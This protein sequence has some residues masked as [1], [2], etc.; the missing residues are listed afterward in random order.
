[1]LCYCLL[2]HS[3]IP[4]RPQHKLSELQ[5]AGAILVRE[6]ADEV[7][8]AARGV[9]EGA[10]SKLAAVVTTGTS[11][12]GHEMVCLPW[13]AGTRRRERG[14][15]ALVEVCAK[16]PELERTLVGQFQAHQRFLVAQ[17]LA[18]SDFLVER[19]HARER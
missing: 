7:K 12:S 18:H 11:A 13:S 2:R 5:R 4:D 8:P 9:L 15:N 14:R 17:H 19:A 1:M 3:F 6:H 16:M 10:Y